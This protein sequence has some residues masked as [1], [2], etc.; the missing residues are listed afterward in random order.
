MKKKKKEKKKCPVRAQKPCEHGGGSRFSLPIPFF[1][2]VP[3]KPYGFCGR[4]APRKKKAA[5]SYPRSRVDRAVGLDS[6]CISHLFF[7][8]P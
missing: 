1:P 5:V 3:D 6:H 7:T 4:T 2:P 8:H